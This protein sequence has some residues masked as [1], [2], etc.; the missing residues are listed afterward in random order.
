ML[1]LSRKPDEEIVIAD[2]IR[3]KVLKVNGSKVVLGIEAP[4]DVRIMRSEI[5]L[6]DP[7]VPAGPPSSKPKRKLANATKSFSTGR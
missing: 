7:T 5:D 1:V 4:D 6:S 2:E 3:V